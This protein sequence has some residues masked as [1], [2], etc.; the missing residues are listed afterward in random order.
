MFISPQLGR[1]ATLFVHCCREQCLF[2]LQ[3]LN[4]H[5]GSPDATLK[6][7]QFCNA[8]LAPS[9]LQKSEVS[10]FPPVTLDQ[11]ITHGLI[12]LRDQIMNI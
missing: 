7:R 9:K 8:M 12:G 11:G 6:Q 2:L 1:Y 10:N 5:D 3:S 4:H